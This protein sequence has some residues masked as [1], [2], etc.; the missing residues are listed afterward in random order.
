MKKEK[1]TKVRM[2]L[3]YDYFDPAI[4]AG[5]PIVSCAN[6]VT[7]LCEDYEFFIYTS[8]R[9]LDGSVLPVVPDKWRSY[10]G[11]AQIMY[12]K[13]MWSARGYSKIVAEIKPDVI[14]I[15]GIYSFVGVIVPLFNSIIHKNCRR[16]IIAPRGM[17][18]KNSLKEKRIKKKLFL[19]VFKMLTKLCNVRWHVTGDQEETELQQLK[20]A[21]Q[22]SSIIRV[23]NV[24]L[25]NK[26]ERH[27]KHSGD[28]VK[29]LTIALISPMKNILFMAS[30][31]FSVLWSRI[32]IFRVLILRNN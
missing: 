10:K 24:P 18:Q 3:I 7:F 12:G 6:M 32:M 1:S 31:S 27:K 4:L 28:V 20:I 2:L 13:K 15:N 19:I 22:M 21:K 14:Y 17:L 9:D 26:I 8:N 23:G 30:I 16:L 11:I 29:L 5:G 25:F